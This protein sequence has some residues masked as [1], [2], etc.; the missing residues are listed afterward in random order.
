VQTRRG[1]FQLTVVAGWVVL[2]IVAFAYARMKSIP[3]GT[4][5][6]VA[7]AFLLEFPFYILAGFDGP[8]EYLAGWKKER[9]ALFMTA[10]AIVPYLAYSLP[11]GRFGF[12]A[13]LLLIAIAGTVSFWYLLWPPSPIAD[14][15]FLALLAAVILYKVFD[16][17]YPSPIPKVAISYLGHIMLIR[18]GAMEV[19][20]I[21]GSVPASFRFLPNRREW[22]TG[23]TYFAMLLPVAG[24]AYAAL[25]L[26]EMRQQ[27]QNPAIALGTFFGILWV[28]ALS[29]E[30]FFRGLLQNWL[31]GWTRSSA[32]GLITTSVLFGMVHLGFRFH[33]EFPNWRFATVAAIAGL[34]YG[35]AARRTSSI[36][37]SMVTHALT[38][39]AWRVFLH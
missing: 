11:T 9:L 34:F 32:F 21:R 17:L 30:F 14:L 36:Q 31:T 12:P 1:S 20:L 10:S 37:S 5:A 25:G 39:T 13:L 6:P 29:E 24:A 8:R 18:T 38:V 26:F 4:A 22:L 7:A 2:A 3:L 33:S 35:L 19:L 15:L 28:V 23:L 27:P 16:I